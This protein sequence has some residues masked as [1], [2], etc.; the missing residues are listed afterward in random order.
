MH[1]FE[2]FSYSFIITVMVLIGRGAWI[3][4]RGFLRGKHHEHQE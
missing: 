4:F 1:W 2:I 3:A